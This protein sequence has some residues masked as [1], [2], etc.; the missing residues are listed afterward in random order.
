[1]AIIEEDSDFFE[2]PIKCLDEIK[3]AK[4]PNRYPHLGEMKWVCAY[5]DGRYDIKSHKSHP[6]LYLSREVTS[7]RP[8]FP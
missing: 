3:F 2:I 8:E 5:D 1:M 7:D 4:I 6:A